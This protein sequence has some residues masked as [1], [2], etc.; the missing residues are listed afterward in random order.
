[1]TK[2]L[3]RDLIEHACSQ[4][5]KVAGRL[6]REGSTPAS[7]AR[8]AIR[9]TKALFPPDWRLAVQGDDSEDEVEVW[10]VEHKRPTPCAHI[11]KESEAQVR[12]RLINAVK[13]RARAS[14]E[15]AI[16]RV[17][18]WSN[19]RLQDIIEADMSQTEHDAFRAVMTAARLVPRRG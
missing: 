2:Q 5:D 18:K 1:M 19:A 7:A 6:V 16:R 11:A 4:L 3:D 14:T 8:A 9:E 12:T 13:E 17:A 10:E 15:P